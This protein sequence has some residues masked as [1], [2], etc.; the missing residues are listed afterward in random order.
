MLF[1]NTRSRKRI[2]ASLAGEC[3]AIHRKWLKMCRL[4]T[5]N[6]SGHTTGTYN[7]IQL[8]GG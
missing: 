6:V 4:H 3:L 5:E 2:F 8:S 1:Q 7:R